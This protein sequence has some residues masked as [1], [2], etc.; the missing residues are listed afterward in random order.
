MKEV[1]V[2]R[3][4]FSALES[5]KT[6]EKQGLRERIINSTTGGQRG[7]AGMVRMDAYS[8]MCN[9]FDSLL[10]RAN[11]KARFTNSAATYADSAEAVGQISV[12]VDATIR[13]YVDSIAGF[14]CREE[15]INAPNALVTIFDAVDAFDDE[16]ISPNLGPVN[17]G[18]LRKSQPTSGMVTSSD[19][20]YTFTPGKRILA[21]TVKMTVFGTAAG[22]TEEVEVPKIAIFDD[23]FGNLMAAPGVISAGAVDYANGTITWTLESTITVGTVVYTPTKVKVDVCIDMTGDPASAGTR[24]HIKGKNVGFLVS[25]TPELLTYEQNL[26]ENVSVTK[27]LGGDMS[28]YLSERLAELYTIRINTSIAEAFDNYEDNDTITI[29][30]STVNFDNTRS[31]SDYF[32]NK[33]SEASLAAKEKVYRLGEP[34]VILAGN[35]GIIPFRKLGQIGVFTKVKSTHVV[36]LVGYLDDVTP[37]LQSDVIKEDATLANPANIPASGDNPGVTYTPGEGIFYMGYKS[38]DGSVAPLLRVIYLPLTTTP[39]VGNFANPVQTTG[40]YYYAENVYPLYKKAIQRVQVF[41]FSEY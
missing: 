30:F 24:T 2:S 7:L 5:N 41:G 16:I 22:S 4:L 3:L 9:T 8:Q 21:K 26:I 10:S 1:N 31:Y 36:G 17:Y 32:Y 19:G 6:N 14:T 38:T 27:T 40:G 39:N 25:T 28:V 11:K 18:K 37:V 13:A 35:K 12:G 15:S 23:G 20:T 29:N 34:N 33:V